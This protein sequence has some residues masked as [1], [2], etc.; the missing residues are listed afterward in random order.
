MREKGG[1]L[2]RRIAVLKWCRLHRVPDRLKSFA[3]TTPKPLVVVRW[4]FQKSGPSDPSAASGPSRL[5]RGRR[6]RK[7]VPILFVHADACSSA[8]SPGVAELEA[9]VTVANDESARRATV[10]LLPKVRQLVE[11][12]TAHGAQIPGRRRRSLELSNLACGR[13]VT[14]A[15]FI[16]RDQVPFL[17]SLCS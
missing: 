3:K 5:W 12:C 16:H 9:L 11:R 1:L 2:W 15:R 7:S 8:N 17:C 10:K 13:H 4:G 6:V 14:I